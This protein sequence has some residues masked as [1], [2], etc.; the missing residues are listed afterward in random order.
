MTASPEPRRDPALDRQ[1]AE[2]TERLRRYRLIRDRARAAR[3]QEVP[4]LARL[5]AATLGTVHPE[6][7]TPIRS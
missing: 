6:P 1:I 2:A 4:R 3:M 7:R 5:I